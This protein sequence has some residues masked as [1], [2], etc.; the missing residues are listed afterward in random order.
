MG[1]L[2]RHLLCPV[3][4]GVVGGGMV[5]EPVGEA[6]YERGALSGPGPVNGLLRSP[7]D[8]EEVVPVYL[9]ALYPV[10][11]GA[12]GYGLGGRLFASRDRYGPLVVLAEEDHGR[13]E[14]SGDV[15]GLVKTPPRRAPVPEV[16]CG[17]FLVALKLHG[18]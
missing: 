6:L 1:P 4:R 18:G 15:Y 14:D 9:Y 7:V 12:L 17:Y 10:S 16:N 13:S 3:S 5:V 11:V 8:G 2:I